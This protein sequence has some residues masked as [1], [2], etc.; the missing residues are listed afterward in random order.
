MDPL[1]SLRN[2]YRLA[3]ERRD[4]AAAFSPEWDAAMEEIEQLRVAAQLAGIPRVDLERP[5]P[6]WTTRR[7]LSPIGE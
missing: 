3:C 4:G 5:A 1:T 7:I 6:V 2:R